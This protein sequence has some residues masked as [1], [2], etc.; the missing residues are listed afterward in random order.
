MSLCQYE[1]WAIFNVSVW[2]TKL[3]Q[4]C[5]YDSCAIYHCVISTAER[6]EI[7]SAWQLGDI[8]LCQND[9]FAIYIWVSMTLVGCVNVWVKYQCLRMRAFFISLFLYYSWAKYYLCQYYSWAV[10]IC[11]SMAA[12][13]NMIVSV[14]LLSDI[15][16]CHYDSWTIYHSVSLTV[17]RYVIVS[18]WQLNDMWLCQYDSLA[19]CNCACMTSERYVILSLWE[20]CDVIFS[21]WHLS[22]MDCVSITAVRYVI[23]QVWQLCDI[24]LCQYDSWAICN[25]VSMI[26][27]WKYNFFRM[28]LLRCVIVSVLRLTYT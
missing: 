4:L 28:T 13:R 12:L 26:A 11:V 6:Y 15:C 9:S 21:V 19:I 20:L 3:T 1:S 18:V 22:D 2:E 17:V 14:W 16:T 10:C 24:Y 25:C 8:S 23:V 5:Q 27:G 7:V